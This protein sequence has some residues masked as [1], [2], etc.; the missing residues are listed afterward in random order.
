MRPLAN[1]RIVLW[2][3]G[4]LWIFH[5]P[6]RPGVQQQTDFHAHHALQIAIALNG[7]FQLHIQDRSV[8]GPAV[9]VGADARHAFEPR[10]L[11][12]LLFIAPESPAGRALTSKLLWDAPVASLPEECLG[13]FPAQ[14]AAAFA[15][16]AR[17]DNR[18]REIGQSLIEKLGGIAEPPMVDARV[19]A[20]MDWA[21]AHLDHGPTVSQAADRV[22]LSADRMSHLFVEQTGL[23]FRTYLLWLRMSN[24]VEAYAAGRSLT[25]AAHAAGFA[26][27][28]HFSRTFRRMF[29]VAAAELRLM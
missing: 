14:M 16:G 22:G 7:A 18:L 24:A 5:V 19:Q 26:D 13:D 23:P 28:S 20:A 4:S 2:Q 1:G 25:D 15:D 6:A 21:V 3:G 10:G 27:S 8:A 9:V 29:G 12:A 11:N 17:G